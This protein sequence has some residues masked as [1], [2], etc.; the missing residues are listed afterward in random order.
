MHLEIGCCYA[1]QCRRAQGKQ[2][3]E[4]CLK[5]IFAQDKKVIMAMT[6]DCQPDENH[7]VV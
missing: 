4:I 2:S 1:G 5:R 7:L 3:I 6:Y